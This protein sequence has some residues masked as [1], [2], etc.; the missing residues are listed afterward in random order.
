MGFHPISIPEYTNMR[1]AT[2]GDNEPTQTSRAGAGCCGLSRSRIE[3]VF[4][5][6]TEFG[7]RKVVQFFAPHRLSKKPYRSVMLKRAKTFPACKG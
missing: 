2:Q 7:E 4:S 1:I 3:L 6:S 5:D